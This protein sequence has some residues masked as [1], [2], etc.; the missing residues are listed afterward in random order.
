MNLEEIKEAVN[1]GKKVHWSNDAYE[2]VKDKIDQWFIKC[3]IN[4][5]SIGLTWKDNVTLNGKEEEFYEAR[6]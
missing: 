1:S 5:H 4:N 6:V 2:V 3:N